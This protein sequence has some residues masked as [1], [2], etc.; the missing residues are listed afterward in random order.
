MKSSP[1]TYEYEGNLVQGVI[2]DRAFTMRSRLHDG[3]AF[4]AWDKE[5]PNTLTYENNKGVPVS[6]NTVQQ[7]VEFPGEKG[8]GFNALIRITTPAG[9]VPGN[10]TRAVRVQRRYR[11]GYDDAGKRIVE[12]LEL[13]KTY[14][15]LD[16]VAGTE[17]PTSTTKSK[18][19]MVMRS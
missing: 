14:R 2:E 4:V 15:V 3:G 8:F 10:I 18:I 9:L 19:T 6:L 1:Y 7:N 11:R 13:V 17:F 12:G 16:G 5:S